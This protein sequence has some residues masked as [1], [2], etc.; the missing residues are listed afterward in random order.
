MIAGRLQ[1]GR[2]LPLP[3]PPAPK[4][5][6][7]PPFFSAPSN[8]AAL[9]WLEKPHAWPDG[10]LLVWGGRA[11]GKTHLLQHWALGRSATQ[12][13][14]PVLHWPFSAAGAM[15]V[16]DADLALDEPLLHL[17]NQAAEQ[18]RLVLLAARM[19]AAGWITRLPDLASRIRATASVAVEPAEDSLL[20]A[21]LRRVFADRQLAAPESV[22]DWLLLHLP[23]TPAALEEAAARL[24]RA[25]LASGGRVT[26]ALATAIVD[27]MAAMWHAD[28]S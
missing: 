4:L 5:V 20:R 23:R 7:S 19:P 17:L 14:G 18:G 16:D 21:I 25:A 13:P 15:V 1:P 8:Q 3:L 2:Q 22:Q 28:A 10:R 11:V 12:I 27:E 24:D 26:R 6:G 9:A